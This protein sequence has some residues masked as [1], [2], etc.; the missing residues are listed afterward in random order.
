MLYLGLRMVKMMRIFSAIAAVCVFFLACASQ[1]VS[2]PG[3]FVPEELKGA[4][5]LNSPPV[6]T[7]KNLVI[8]G[9]QIFPAA[10]S[11]YEL[12]KD[13]RGQIFIARK[14]AG[15]AFS[16][17]VDDDTY[18]V[19]AAGEP[20]IGIT[21]TTQKRETARDAAI[22][23]AQYKTLRE[24]RNSVISSIEDTGS[25]YNE[26]GRGSEQLV[27]T[28]K[29]GGVVVSLFDENSNCYII[30]EVSRKDLKKKALS[31]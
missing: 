7:G 5:E 24:I 25:L 3:V 19:T 27:G 15:A 31:Y 2:R 26:T 13:D 8:S 28:I 21:E 23:S 4:Q 20:K 14:S 6:Y 10:P 16:G 18:R 12:R 1:E 29:G 9:E 17:W 30:Y 11:Q 22:L